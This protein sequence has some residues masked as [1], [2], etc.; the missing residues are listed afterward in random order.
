MNFRDATLEDWNRVTHGLGYGGRFIL[1]KAAQE[2][3]N[4]DASQLKIE[5]PDSNRMRR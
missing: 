3:N 5:I 4:P 1:A 2:R